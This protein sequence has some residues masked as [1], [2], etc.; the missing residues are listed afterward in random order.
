MNQQ[1]LNK[2]ASGKSDQ[3]SYLKAGIVE[4]IVNDLLLH[5]YS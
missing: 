1:E 5:F 4:K 3:T 2:D